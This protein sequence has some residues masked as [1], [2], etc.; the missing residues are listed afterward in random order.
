MTPIGSRRIM[1]VCPP[2][3]SL[4]AVPA[5]WRAAPAKKCRLSI[6]N[7]ISLSRASL[8]GLPAS[9]ESNSASS[10]ECAS[11]AIASFSSAAARSPCVS[12]DQRPSLNA[13]R[14]AATAC[15]TSS[16]E[17]RGTSA[18]HSPVA[19][20]TSSTVLPELLLTSSPLMRSLKSAT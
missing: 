7:G 10:E 16:I 2:V 9:S 3:Y 17:L 13:S 8:I 11:N 20:P 12:P 15:S 5:R 18:I 6:A 4:V 14:A 1:L 19:G